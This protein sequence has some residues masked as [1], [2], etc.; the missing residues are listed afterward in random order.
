MGRW[1]ADGHSD[2][3]GLFYRKHSTDTEET[4]ATTNE[5]GN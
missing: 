3:Y 4:G 2:F 1:P 5:C